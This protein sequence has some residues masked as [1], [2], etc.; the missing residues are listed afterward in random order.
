MSQQLYGCTLVNELNGRVLS[1][2]WFDRGGVIQR[3]EKNN[4][5]KMK[6]I[7]HHIVIPKISLPRQN[8]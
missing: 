4:K 8:I 6:H 5:L 3:S 1:L 2:E 7:S